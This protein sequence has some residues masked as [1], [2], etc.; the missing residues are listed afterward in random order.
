MAQASLARI[1][2]HCN[3]L[4]R[5]HEVNDYDGAFNGL[6]V[7]NRGA[8]RRVAAA[9]DASL[10]T[11]RLAIVAGANLLVVHHGLF[12]SARQPWTGANYQLLRFLLENDLAV[13]SAHL[14]LDLHPK[15]GNNIQLC[16]AL[17]FKSLRPF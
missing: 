8:I 15:L 11:A 3:R 14:P 12:W 6:Q 13:Y 17:G 10:S 4:L 2:A 9:V 5:I 1:V 16:R 7:E